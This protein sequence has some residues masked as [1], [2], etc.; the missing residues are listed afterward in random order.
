M[1]D[2]YGTYITISCLSQW[3]EHQALMLLEHFDVDEY[4][5]TVVIL[6][7]QDKSREFYLTNYPGKHFIYFQLEFDV[8]VQFMFFH[9]FLFLSL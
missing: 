2:Y 6:G 4:E 5:N 1:R 8:Q 9:F 3:F 7:V